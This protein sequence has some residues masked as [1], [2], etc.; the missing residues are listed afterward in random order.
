MKKQT[1][2]QKRQTQ[3]QQK[4]SSSNNSAR[5]R[6]R[7]DGVYREAHQ[8]DLIR[9]QWGVGHS[10]DWI[11][12]LNGTA[13]GIVLPVG[14]VDNDVLESC[15]QAVLDMHGEPAPETVYDPEFDQYLIPDQLNTLDLGMPVI[16]MA[17]V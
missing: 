7:D 9:H 10:P 16:M 6:K 1:N 11:A 8:D 5:Y 15:R 2:K 12:V 4:K 13:P 3:R 17:Y 14:E